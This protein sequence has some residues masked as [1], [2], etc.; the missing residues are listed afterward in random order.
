MKKHLSLLLLLLLS[1]F[2][3]LNAE[4]IETQDLTITAPDT[5]TT[6]SSEVG[7]PISSLVSMANSSET[8]MLVI[9]VYEVD[10]DL[11]S[12]LQQ[13][14]V[15]G[16]NNFF[17]NASYVGEIR[18]EK[19]GGVAA[20]AVEF[21]IDVLGEPHRG[22][23]YA[24]QAS[25]GLCFTFYAYKT[26]TIPTSKSILSTLRFKENVDVENKSLADRLSD[27]SKLI[28]SNPLKIGDNVLQTKFDVDN[29]AK[30]I[31]YE[32]K[33][34]DTVADDATAEYMQSYM[35]ENV[36]NFFSE[37]LNSSSLLQE[38]ARAGYFFRYRGVDKNGRQIYNVKLTP[39]DYAPLLR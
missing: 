26:G 23:A 17:T 27:F 5:W 29:T 35:Q 32:Y 18:D 11:Q 15:E 3:G 14:V 19:L 12:F 24:A 33:L 31:L 10:I 8:E 6:E 2:A 16:Q 9:G 36:L 28:A 20:K 13:Q 25:V 4:T 39:T 30:R 37:D 34:T 21:Q 7:Y 22:T 1:T 38:A